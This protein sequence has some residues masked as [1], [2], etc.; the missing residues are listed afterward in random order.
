LPLLT[1]LFQQE[2]SDEKARKGEKDVNPEE[3]SWKKRLKEMVQK[4]QE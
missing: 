2:R 1:I 3:A 4:H